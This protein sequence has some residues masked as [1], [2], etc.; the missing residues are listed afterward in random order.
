MALA[1]QSRVGGGVTILFDETAVGQKITVLTVISAL[2][3][4]LPV[5]TAG[6]PCDAAGAPPFSCSCGAA[7]MWAFNWAGFE[8]IQASI[9][10]V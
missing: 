4:L 3:P 5:H 8:V 7:A 2:E 10:P 6:H 9:G 1:G